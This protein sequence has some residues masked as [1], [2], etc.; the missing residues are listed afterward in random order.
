[1]RFRLDG[2]VHSGVVNRITKRAT[3]LTPDPRGERYSDGK[4]YL[5]FYVPL[6]ML[7]AIDDFEPPS[8]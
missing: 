8:E 6:A 5:K 4:R 7:E 3:V 1:V 2:Q